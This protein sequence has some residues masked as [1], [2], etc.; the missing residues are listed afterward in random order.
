M[1]S[2]PLPRAVWYH[3]VESK[4]S[5]F[6]S[7]QKAEERP[8]F[9]R[10]A[11][12]FSLFLFSYL[13]IMAIGY[14]LGG[15]TSWSA[16]LPGPSGTVRQIWQGNDTFTGAPRPEFEQAWVAMLPKER[17]FIRISKNVE[18]SVT[19]FHQLHCVYA[20]QIAYHT[21]KKDIHAD[22]KP[23]MHVNMEPD[24]IEHCFDYI[25]QAL[26]CHADTNLEYNDP[27]T[28][29]TTGWGTE[30]VCRDFD[31]V[32]RWADDNGVLKKQH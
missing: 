32:I 14:V 4:D 22:F 12:V 17:G 18:H 15:H 13:F 23:L 16:Q 9:L 31:A 24:H 27:V 11:I 3:P 10:K 20:L 2:L 21:L 26:M 8:S 5:E 28:K 7:F 6:G 29:V 19:V 1:W 25:R 30:R